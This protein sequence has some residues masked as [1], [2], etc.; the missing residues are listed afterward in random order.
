FNTLNINPDDYKAE[1]VPHSDETKYSATFI[2]TEKGIIGEF[3]AG[4]HWQLTQGF[5]S[6]E[7]ISFLYDWDKL[8]L[9][10]PDETTA[11]MIKTML[12]FLHITKN[13]QDL[14][15]TNLNAKFTNTDYLQG[16]FEYIIWPGN[17]KMFVDYNRLIPDMV[18]NIDFQLPEQHNKLTGICASPGIAKGKVKIVLDPTNNIFENK[19]I[20]VCRMTMIDYVPLMKKA[21]G[22]ITEEGNILSHAAIV[23]RE[24]KIPCIVGVKNVLADLKDGDEIELDATTGNITIK[25]R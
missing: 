6:S 20:L 3:V 23:S 5:F 18:G 19:S 24:M 11:D 22:I 12:D 8:T 4:G 2:I 1:V 9:S 14:L 10:K 7:P 13:K 25:N 15:E 21:G 17:K 16:Y